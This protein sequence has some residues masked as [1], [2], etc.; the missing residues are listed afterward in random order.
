MSYCRFSSDDFQCDVYCY[1]AVYGGFTTHVASNRPDKND[2]LPPPV[3][4]EKGREEEWLERHRQVMAWIKHAERRPLGL[5]CDGQ[6]FNDPTAKK[7]AMRLQSLKKM[8][9]HVPQYAIDA[10]LAEAAEE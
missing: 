8:G 9:Y 4:L 1:E 6:T 3:P 5:P 2:S 10:L 7:A